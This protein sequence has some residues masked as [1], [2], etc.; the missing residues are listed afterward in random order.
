MDVNVTSLQ[1]RVK[2]EA[3]SYLEQLLSEGARKLL[4]AA[5]ENEVAEYLQSQSG[6][7]SESGERS[8]VRNGHLPERDLVTG[9][10]PVKIRQPRVRHRDGGSFSSEILPKS[11]PIRAGSGRTQRSGDVERGRFSDSYGQRLDGSKGGCE[12]GGLAQTMQEVL[13]KRFNAT[14]R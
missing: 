12:M 8:V 1:E 3:K 6:R 11:S 10:G 4:Q 2:V 9:V 14:L 7:R 5:I 13:P